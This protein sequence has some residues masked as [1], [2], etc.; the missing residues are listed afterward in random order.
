MTAVR[1]AL[2]SGLTPA[3]AAKTSEV[4]RL[5]VSD[6]ELVSDLVEFLQSRADVVTARVAK[7][8]VELALLGSR[9]APPRL[10]LDSLVRA[11]EAPRP[12]RVRLVAVSD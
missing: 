1:A 6:P 5:G 9:E 11:W 7:D 8:E 10:T 3:S 2:G 4:V 12:V